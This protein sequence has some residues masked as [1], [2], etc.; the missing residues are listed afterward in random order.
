MPNRSLPPLVRVLALALAYFIAGRLGL[1]LPSYGSHITL[2]W[3]PT[4]IAVAALL[5]WGFG[6]WP[7]VALGAL[8]VN[9]ADGVAGPVAL[10]IAAGNTAGAGADGV[11]AAADGFSRGL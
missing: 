4:G 11:A 9:L 7:G 2:V 1:M 5:R 3:L 8:A 6:G 10:G